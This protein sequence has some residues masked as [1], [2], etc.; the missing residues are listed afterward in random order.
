MI[1]A[2]LLAAAAAA[3]WWYWPVLL[4]KTA[5]AILTLEKPAIGKTAPD[6]TLEDAEATPV[7]LGD[8]KGKVVLL[9]FWATWCEPCQTEVPWFIEFQKEWKARGFTVI[10]VSMDEDGWESVKPWIA[11]RDVNYPIVVV[12]EYVRRLYGGIDVLP[13]TLIIGRDGKVAFMHSSLIPREQY[14][15]EIVQLLTGPVGSLRQLVNRPFRTRDNSSHVQTGR[16]SLY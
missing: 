13:T 1:A 10:G 7:T 4:H 6:F 14:E 16:D 8:F 11:E 2:G 3:L 9:N 5:M 15:R 12:N